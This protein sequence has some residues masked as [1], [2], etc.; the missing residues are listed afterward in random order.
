MREIKMVALR[1]V[2]E[3]VREEVGILRS[4]RR[5]H[6]QRIAVVEFADGERQEIPAQFVNGGLGW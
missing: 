4:L 1:E 2:G 3:E 5:D 6:G